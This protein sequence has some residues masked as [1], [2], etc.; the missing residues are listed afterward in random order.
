M[1]LLIITQ[2]VDIND[3]IL[4]FFHRWILEF[5]KHYEQITVIALQV[6]E[7]DLPKNVKVFSLGKGLP[8]AFLG[9]DKLRYI[10]RFYKYIW[11]ERDNYD[12]VFVHMN[13]IYIV[14]GGLIW[15]FL[16]K[17]IGL[18]YTHKSVDIKLRIAEK[19]VNNIFTAS[20]KSFR[21]NTKKVKIMGHG[22][23][24]DY[25]KTQKLK[26]KSEKIN[27]LHIGRISRTK[28]IHL[29]IKVAEILKKDR[30]KFVVNIVGGPITNE[31]QNYFKRLKEDIAD[32]K[33]TEY[34][35]FVGAVPPSEISSYYKKNDIL[36]NLSD[37]GS[38]DKVVLEAIIS[39]IQ[40]LV[41]NEAFEDILPE[42]NKTTKEPKQIVE[43]VIKIV[44]TR[45]NPSLRN[46]VLKNHN[47]KN[48][49][50]E[51]FKLM[52]NKTL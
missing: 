16:N 32:K 25:F 46:Y 40:I 1:R 15:K 10:Y 35:N 50:L 38:M 29:F 23:D 45:L 17:K 42:E 30:I 52:S 13:P 3:D 47:L 19:L 9:G 8:R 22:I 37:T 14:L 28:N 24:V 51:L 41:S 26:V 20:N 39:E 44:N 5:A 27:I 31:D 33:L 18:W 36:I 11:S 48:L 34:F 4:G 12:A 6:G 2:K 7:Y 21:L 49:I 43:D